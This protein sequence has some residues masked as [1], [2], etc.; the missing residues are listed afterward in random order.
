MY[1]NC[2]LW[3]QL[4]STW[5][6]HHIYTLASQLNSTWL[7]H[8]IYTLVSQ[9]DSTWLHQ[10]NYTLPSQLNSTWL[11]QHNYTLP[12]QLDST[13]QHNYTL[14]S[15]L[16]S[17]QRWRCLKFARHSSYV[18]FEE[19][20]L[21]SL[22]ALLLIKPLFTPGGR[23]EVKWVYL[24]VKSCEVS[25][26]FVAIVRVRVSLF[27]ALCQCG[28]LKKRSGYERSLV[29]KEGVAGEPIL[30]LNLMH[31]GIPA[32]GIPSDWLLLTVYV[33]ILSFCLKRSDAWYSERD[34]CTWFWGVKIYSSV[35]NVVK[36]MSDQSSPWIDFRKSLQFVS[37]FHSRIPLA[38]DLACRLIDC[39]AQD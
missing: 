10:H 27:Q 39:R 21:S 1:Y 16:H 33:N 30:I 4:N 36:N 28:R 35:Q 13:R 37:P 20:V 26:C 7:H 18:V 29:E 14:P 32:P 12:S 23:H 22:I 5:L 19:F 15:Q 8:H 2:T 17:T 9:L 3:S 25:L 31:S 6:H 24:S 11:Q 38:A 34:T